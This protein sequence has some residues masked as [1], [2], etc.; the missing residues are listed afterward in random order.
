MVQRVK[1]LFVTGEVAPF[2]KAESSAIGPLARHLSESLHV[3]G[4]F[5]T[6]IMMPR[7]GLISERRNRLH[8][9]IRL[10]GASIPMGGGKETLKVKVASIPG[11]RLQV[12]FMDN[13]RFF[14]RKGLH[15]DKE[16]RL[17]QDNHERSMF[18]CRS[19]LETVRRL[20]WKPDIVHAF[21][22]ISGLLPVLLSTSEYR[23]KSDHSLFADTRVIYTPDNVEPDANLTPALASQLSRLQ[24]LNGSAPSDLTEFIGQP[25]ADVGLKYSDLSAFPD[26]VPPAKEAV[27]LL[28]NASEIAEQTIKLYESA[29]GDPAK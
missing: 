22:W 28:G 13:A 17:Y 6:R 25:I 14:K 29:L 23:E 20:R 19:V 1:V 4:Q 15:Q 27:Q 9:V 26:S 8:E 3:S 10:C 24:M 5:E 18:F 16:G 21:G 11:I 2:T 7:Y 12:Y